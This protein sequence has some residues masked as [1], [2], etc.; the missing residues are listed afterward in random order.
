MTC[1]MSQD[2]AAYVLGALSA[3]DRLEFERHLEGCGHC[4]RSLG[5]SP[6]SWAA[7]PRRRQ[8]PGKDTGRR[9]AASHAAA[10]AD[11]GTAE[12]GGVA[13]SS[14]PGWRRCSWRSVEPWGWLSAAGR[15]RTGKGVVARQMDPVGEGSRGRRHTRAGRLGHPPRPHLQ[16]RPESVEY[17]L[18]P[19]VRYVL[20]VRTDSGETEQVGS[21]L[22]ESDAT[23]RVTAATAEAMGT[24]PRS[25]FR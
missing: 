8:R 11:P 15:T 13:R 24:S 14:R 3:T 21:W 12:P 23:V 10:L 4:T 22:S 17:Q 19:Q 7:W 25:R 6:D 18:P 5:S 16:V 20:V 1:S 9:A 2:A